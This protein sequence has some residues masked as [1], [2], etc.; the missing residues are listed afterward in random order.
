VGLGLTRWVL[1]IVAAAGVIAT[2]RN[3]IDRPVQRTVV[4]STK[5]A[6]DAGFS[7][8]AISFARAYLA[9]SSNPLVHQRSLSQFVSPIGDRDVG[10]TPAPA[11]SQEVAWVGVAAEGTGPGRLRVYTVAVATTRGVRYLAVAVTQGS[12]G[13]PVLARYPSLVAAPAIDQSGAL[14]GGSLPAVTN[15]GASAVL[16]R[17]LRNYLGGSAENLAAD[18]APGA[19]VQPVGPGLTL[20]AVVRLA[21]EPSGAVLATVRASDATGDVFTLAYQVSLRESDGRWEIR[22][23]GP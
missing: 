4:I 23:I 9:W 20:S 7:W 12:D 2:A 5:Q 17:A 14:D 22:R 6:S 11:S 1:Y 18:L 16:N 3:A 15:R 19:A 21:L 10:L 8:F 13:L